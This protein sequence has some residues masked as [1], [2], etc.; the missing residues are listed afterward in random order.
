MVIIDIIGSLDGEEIMEE[1]AD[2]R[3]LGE[4]IS[5]DGRNIKNIKARIAKGVGIV[6]KVMTILETIPFGRRYFEIG[7]LLRDSM[8]TANL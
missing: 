6:S 2:E 5:T 3:Y 1:K 7:I 8:L 4:I